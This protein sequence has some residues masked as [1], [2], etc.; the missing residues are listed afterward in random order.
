MATRYA[1]KKCKKHF[2]DTRGVTGFAIVASSGTTE[3]WC[4]A[5]S[6]A[7]LA[8]FVTDEHLAMTFHP[9]A[10]TL[11]AMNSTKRHGQASAPKEKAEFDPKEEQSDEFVSLVP[12]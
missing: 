7:Q 4:K 5:C 10:Q 8:S 12:D 6:N 3:F 1:C 2:V 11:V 9:D